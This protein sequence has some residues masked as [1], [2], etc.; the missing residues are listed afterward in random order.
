MA[1]SKETKA[2]KTRKAKTSIQTE[3]ISDSIVTTTATA[4]NNDVNDINDVNNTVANVIDDNKGEMINMMNDEMNT[5]TNAN[6]NTNTDAN[7]NADADDNAS[8]NKGEIEMMNTNNNNATVNS[9]N[10]TVA[11]SSTNNYV[12]SGLSQE[13]L[14][15]ILAAA[16]VD[17]NAIQIAPAKK[18][19]TVDKLTYD[20]DFAI[21]KTGQRFQFTSLSEEE[22]IESMKTGLSPAN[23]S[24]LAQAKKIKEASGFR[25]RVVTDNRP[26]EDKPGYQIREIVKANLDTIDAET[27]K[28][29]QDK[30]FCKKQFKL[31]YPLLLNITNLSPEEIA[32]A[33]KDAK[34]RSRFAPQQYKKDNEIYLMTNDLY[35]KNLPLISAFFNK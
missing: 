14:Q 24:I 3:V 32:I 25:T 9:S 29:L 5:N 8:N 15:A 13:Q 2:K 21:D 34:G 27:L 20:G 6:T 7:A 11:A 1:N 23:L 28:N 30:E 12:V 10:N 18:A 33:R 22:K 16:G 31:Q 35:S 4:D 26:S 17:P 19:K